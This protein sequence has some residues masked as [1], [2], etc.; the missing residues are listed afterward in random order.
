LQRLL[1]LGVRTI[2]LRIKDLT[3]IALVSEIQKAIALAHGFNARLFVNDHWEIALQ[4]KAY[5][6]HLGQEDLP[7]A[8]IRALSAARIRLGVSV[9]SYAEAACVAGMRPSYTA[10]GSIFATASKD[11]DYKPVGVDEFQ[12]FRQVIRGP[13]VAIGG[14][15]LEKA[16]EL[17]AAG[18]N[19]LAVI[20]DVLSAADPVARAG[21]WLEFWKRLSPRSEQYHF[22]I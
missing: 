14:I 22:G 7:D 1:P 6:V 11:I 17:V 4:H 8:D 21:S 15:T 9:R 16:P 19:G 13:V 12:R 10:I 5:G 2:Q 18:A 20:S 3:G